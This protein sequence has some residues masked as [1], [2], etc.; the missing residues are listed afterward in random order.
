MVPSI[1]Q[2][3]DIFHSLILHSKICNRIYEQRQTL[4]H[5]VDMEARN[6]SVCA[7]EMKICGCKKQDFDRIG[8]QNNQ[9]Y[10]CTNC[11]EYCTSENTDFF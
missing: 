6:L 9:A 3:S 8:T 5:W 1:D 2:P 7:K 4:L 11:G 10:K